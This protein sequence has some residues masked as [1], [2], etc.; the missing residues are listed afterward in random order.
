VPET[1]RSE[2]AAAAPAKREPDRAKLKPRVFRSELNVTVRLQKKGLLMC[3]SRASDRNQK[4]AP[5]RRQKDYKHGQTK[6]DGTNKQTRKTKVHHKQTNGTA[7][8]KKA[9][10]RIDKISTLPKPL[11]PK[12]NR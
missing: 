6:T 8:Y 3:L 1:G 10:E 12:E 2:A 9:D 7:R 4:R 5:K 11:F